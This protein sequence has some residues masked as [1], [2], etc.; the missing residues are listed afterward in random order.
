ME[1]ILLI[2]NI[3]FNLLYL[4]SKSVFYFYFKC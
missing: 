3:I 2:S 4:A 1:V